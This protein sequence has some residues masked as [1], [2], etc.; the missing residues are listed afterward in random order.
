RVEKKQSLEFEA[1]SSQPAQSGDDRV[2]NDLGFIAKFW[3]DG[4][5]EAN[6]EFITK[7]QLLPLLL[8]FDLRIDASNVPIKEDPSPS[9]SFDPELPGVASVSSDDDQP[10]DG[11]SGGSGGD[12]GS[13]G[14]SGGGSSSVL[15]ELLR[16]VPDNAP[17]ENINYP[18]D[19]I[20]RIEFIVED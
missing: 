4:E 3:P 10:P 18:A 17:A 5:T 14:H 1:D 15:D 16:L 7:N 20:Q 2:G 6:H 8:S 19:Y 9:K 11:G 13:G 12:G